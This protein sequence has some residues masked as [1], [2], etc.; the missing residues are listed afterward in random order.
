MY[1]EDCGRQIC[2][3]LHPLLT[4]TVYFSTKVRYPKLLATGDEII[5]FQFNFTI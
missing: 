5:Q 2:F 3:R 4:L 1:M